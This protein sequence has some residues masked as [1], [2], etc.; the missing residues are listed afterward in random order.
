MVQRILPVSFKPVAVVPVPPVFV[1]LIA[2]KPVN[3]VQYVLVELPRFE[4]TLRI[5][6]S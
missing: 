4:N 5:S 6:N 2:P 1:F 3:L